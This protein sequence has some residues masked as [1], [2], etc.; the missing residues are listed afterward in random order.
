[1]KRRIK[2]KDGNDVRKH[3]EKLGLSYAA[4]AK[5]YDV[6]TTNVWNWEHGT[7]L[8]RYFEDRVNTKES[9]AILACISFHGG[10]G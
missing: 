2:F 7:P 6:P 3:R 10:I 5:R 8:N 4:Y 9:C 1:M